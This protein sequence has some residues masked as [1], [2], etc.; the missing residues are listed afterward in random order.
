MESKLSLMA[1]AMLRR[2]ESTASPPMPSRPDVP[3]ICMR[4]AASKWQL[5]APAPLAGKARRTPPP[6]SDMFMVPFSGMESWVKVT[7]Y[8]ALSV[9]A[10]SGTSM[11]SS[12]LSVSL[13]I[14][15]SFTETCLMWISLSFP[16]SMT[17]VFSATM[18]TLP[19]IVWPVNH[20]SKSLAKLAWLTETSTSCGVGEW[21]AK[22]KPP[23]A[24]SVPKM[25]TVSTSVTTPGLLEF[26]PLSPPFL[27]AFAS[28]TTFSSEVSAPS[29][30]VGQDRQAT[31]NK[32]AKAFGPTGRGAIAEV[33]PASLSLQ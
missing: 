17:P 19:G 4:I 12:S 29:T 7:S 22:E 1:L 15:V 30:K 9:Q 10:K 25:P 24:W 26:E 3:W 2:A 20:S 27:V 13:C 32:A 8:L 5:P 33:S 18:S 16:S 14:V 21:G 31:N 11:M 28:F 6:P 23:L